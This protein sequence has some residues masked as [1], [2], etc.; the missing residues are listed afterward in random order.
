[1]GLEGRGNQDIA[2]KDRAS[3]ARLLARA[4]EGRGGCVGQPSSSKRKVTVIEDETD[5]PSSLAG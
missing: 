4:A 2:R 1:M 5:R 3:R